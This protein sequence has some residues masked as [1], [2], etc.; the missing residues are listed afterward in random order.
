MKPT[1]QLSAP[2]LRSPRTSRSIMTDVLIGLVPPAVGAIGYFG[3]PAVWLLAVTMAVCQITE[4]LCLLC[5]RRSGFDASALVTGALLA[6]S[7]PAGTPLWAAALAGVFAIAVVKQLLGGI[8][9]NL[10][11]PAMAGRALLLVALPQVVSGYSLPDAV[12]S[13]TPLSQIGQL[14]LL[15]MLFGQKNGSIGET[16]GVL[17]LLGGAYLYCRGVIRLRTPVACLAAFSAVIWI[18]GGDG[19]F[20]GNVTAHLLSGSILLGAFFLVTDYASAPLTAGGNVLFAVGVGILTAILRLAGPY[21]EGVCFAILLMNLLAPLLEWLTRPAVYGTL[22]RRH[23]G[24]AAH[25]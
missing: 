7:L 22:P 1:I 9:R 24:Y 17:I 3:W 14:E 5:R 11:N 13:A 18:F 12:S 25:S 10:L 16:S 2:H 21:P 20:T 15:P 23:P 4:S 19:C 8:G 6:L